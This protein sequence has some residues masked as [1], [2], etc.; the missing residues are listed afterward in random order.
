M[1]YNPHGFSFLKQDDSKIKR[2]IY[3]LIEK[4]TAIFNRKCI[5]VGCSKGEYEEAKKLNK[6][7]IC[8]NNGI[9]VEKLDKQRC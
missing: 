3:W 1:F 6:N 8:I 4:M 2:T 7:S 5:I 9:D